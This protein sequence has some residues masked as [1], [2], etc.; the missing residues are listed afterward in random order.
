MG[1]FNKRTCCINDLKSLLLYEFHFIGCNSVRAHYNSPIIYFF[2]F[3]YFGY[4]RLLQLFNNLRIVYDRTK[5]VNIASSLVSTILGHIYLPLNP[6]TKAR[7]FSKKDF[8]WK[9]LLL[10]M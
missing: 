4:A 2:N 10:K 9:Y 5:C 1:L 7:I 3:I 6:K 8:H